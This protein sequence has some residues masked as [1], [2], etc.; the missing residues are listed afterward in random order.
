MP[1]IRIDVAL[2]PA[3]VLEQLARYGKDWHESRLPL[4]VRQAGFYRF[5]LKVQGTGFALQLP[6]AKSPVILWRGSVVDAEDGAGSL[7]TAAAEL[8]RIS[9]FT[10]PITLAV[11]AGWALLRGTGVG[12]ALFGLLLAV[13]LLVIAHR[14][15]L[16]QANREAKLCRAILLRATQARP[17]SSTDGVD[18]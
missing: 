7:V 17:A 5:P 6:H 1:K 12:F 4:E 11:G 3:Q 15:Q 2:P 14:L 18:T 13:A 16:R 10:I 8:D 9:L